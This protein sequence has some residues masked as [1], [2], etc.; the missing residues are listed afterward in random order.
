[1]FLTN[2]FLNR[3]VSHKNTGFICTVI[4]HIQCSISY[5]LRRY[6]FISTSVGVIHQGIKC[7]IEPLPED[8]FFSG[9]EIYVKTTLTSNDSNAA[10]PHTTM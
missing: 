4:L 1:M 7:L 9:S 3:T 5:L 2:E 10:Y 6:R 8:Y